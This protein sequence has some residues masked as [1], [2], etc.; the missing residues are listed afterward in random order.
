MIIIIIM[1]IIFIIFIISISAHPG[2]AIEK[3]W[4]NN[5]S[6]FITIY[7]QQTEGLSYAQTTCPRLTN[8]TPPTTKLL[9]AAS[10]AQL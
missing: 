7:G 2:L 10:M 5:Y 1:I 8:T 9:A 3:K 6:P 4:L